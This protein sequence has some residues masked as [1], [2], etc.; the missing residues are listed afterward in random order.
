MGNRLCGIWPYIFVVVMDAVVHG[1]IL[2]AIY[3]VTPRNLLRLFFSFIFFIYPLYFSVDELWS[4]RPSVCAA[5]SGEI[6]INRKHYMNTVRKEVVRDTLLPVTV[7]IPVYTESN[8]VIFQTIRDSLAAVK[9]YRAFSGK[10]ANVVVSDDGLA[11]LC[12]G[13]LTAEKAQ[14]LFHAVKH[15]PSGLSEKEQK[16]AERILFYRTHQIPYVVRPAENRGLSC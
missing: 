4:I 16:A 14:A 13:G 15:A 6:P 10:V 9:R 12:G 11:P 7:S 3:G 5:L 2:F 8:D 1:T